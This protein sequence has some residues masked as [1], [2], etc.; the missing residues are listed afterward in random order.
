MLNHILRFDDLFAVSDSALT[1][2]I[3]GILLKHRMPCTF[4]VIPFMCD[5]AD[6]LDAGRVN[7]RPFSA[8]K[9]NLLKPLLDA[10]LAEVALHGYAH[11]TTSFQREHQEFSDAM[12]APVQRQLIR[13]G[14]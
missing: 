11:L 2:S 3:V 5:P 8:E 13:A 4:A 1:E 12:P 6:L 9:A 10:Q 7:L 14:R